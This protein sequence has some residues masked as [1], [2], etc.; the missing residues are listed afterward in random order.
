MQRERRDTN[1]DASFSDSASEV[2]TRRINSTSSESRE[3]IATM[4]SALSAVGL[5][6]EKVGF[7]WPLRFDFISLAFLRLRIHTAWRAVF[8]V[9]TERCLDVKKLTPASTAQSGHVS[10]G[11][12]LSPAQ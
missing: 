1:L 9:L 4:S 10:K 5:L 8:G 2:P 11:V 3:A 12:A 6:D 7:R